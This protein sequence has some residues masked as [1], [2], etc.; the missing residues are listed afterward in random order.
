MAGFGENL[1]LILLNAVKTYHCRRP[2]PWRLSPPATAECSETAVSPAELTVCRMGLIA[3]R[4]N[5]ARV[6]QFHC[7]RLLQGQYFVFSK[8]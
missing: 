5:S 3:L 6:A 8:S 4:S 2:R 1:P 7:T